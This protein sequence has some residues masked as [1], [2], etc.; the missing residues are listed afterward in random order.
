MKQFVISHSVY[1]DKTQRATLQT[2]GS[3]IEVLGITVPVCVFEGGK[4]DEPAKEIVCKY[5]IIHSAVP[6]EPIRMEGNGYIITFNRPIQC[7]KLL[8]VKEGGSGGLFFAFKTMIRNIPI[9]HQV[10]ILNLEMFDLS[11]C[12][13][14]LDQIVS[15]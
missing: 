8:S 14:H 1:L 12:C 13:F 7:E 2:T 15:K 5:K 4:T 6:D 11:V 9:L 10:S 3:F